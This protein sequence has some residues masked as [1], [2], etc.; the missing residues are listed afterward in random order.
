MNLGGNEFIGPLPPLFRLAQLDGLFLH[1]NGFTGG[2]PTTYVTLS[3]L[4][5]LQLQ[6]NLLGGALSGSLVGALSRLT[7]LLV[8]QNRLEGSIPAEI[9]THQSLRE[10]NLS[11]NRFSGP[12]G[13]I[14]PS[15]SQCTL[16]S[17]SDT[18]CL[19]RI[20]S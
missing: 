11:F 3:N 20:W 13:T 18:N 16:Q 9:R 7:T 12:V 1:A 2:I 15:I 19:V 8:N 10:L 4:K 6:S 14:P 5:A 17:M